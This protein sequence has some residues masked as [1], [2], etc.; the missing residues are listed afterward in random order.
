MQFQF[1]V[2]CK[3]NPFQFNLIHL[4]SKFSIPIQFIY[5]VNVQF[6]FKSV[7]KLFSSNSNSVP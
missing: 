6:Q 1:N 7:H 3:I 5:K 2:K 4:E